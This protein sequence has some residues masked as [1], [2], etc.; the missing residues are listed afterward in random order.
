MTMVISTFPAYGTA[1][2]TCTLIAGSY[3][4]LAMFRADVTSSTGFSPLV[5]FTPTAPPNLSVDGALYAAN[6]STVG[7]T[8]SFTLQFKRV[9][10]VDES[11][12]RCRA[13]VPNAVLSAEGVAKIFLRR[14]D[15]ETRVI[16]PSPISA[17]Q[18]VTI[19]CTSIEFRNFTV[20]WQLRRALDPNF[21]NFVSIAFPEQNLFA[22][23]LA[24]STKDIGP[25][26]YRSNNVVVRT[27]NLQSNGDELRCLSGS[28]GGVSDSTQLVVVP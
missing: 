10:C 1:Q 17:N 5:A 12:Y 25:C 14:E 26:V 21:A 22:E 3:Q 16:V 13:L 24:G 28:T 19:F 2:I 9:S 11:T 7:F 6:Q 20:V 23:D 8:H 15:Q 4:I 18:V 27:F